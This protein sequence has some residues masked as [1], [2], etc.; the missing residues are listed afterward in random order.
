MALKLNERYPGRFDNPSADY[1]Q[2]SF[3]NRTTP[4][5]KDGSYLEK[6]WANDKEGFFQS[7]L[8]E[9]GIVADGDVDRVGASQYYEALV[10]TI[11]SEAS[12]RLLGAPQIFTTSGTY[13]PT[14]GMVTCIIEAVGGGGGGGFAAATGSG[15]VGIAGGGGSGAYAMGRFT[16][17]DIGA[18]KAVTIGAGGAGGTNGLSSPGGA[19][20]VGSLVVCP[21]GLGTGGHGPATPPLMKVGAS[22]AAAPTGGNIKSSRGNPGGIAFSLTDIISGAGGNSPMFGA[23]GGMYAVANQSGVA[24]E[25]PGSGG[26]GGCSSNGV[27]RPGGAGHAG[28]VIIWEYS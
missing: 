13:T 5:A 16:A 27:T 22:I 15:Q 10:E 12:G 23:G 4:T 2:G 21:G 20:S 17:V 19:T 1:P 18:S 3:K 9:A 11:L 26:S 24:G 8:S 28:A 14:P 25:T 6:D 7:L